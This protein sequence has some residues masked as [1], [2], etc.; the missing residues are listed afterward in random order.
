MPKTLPRSFRNARDV[1]QRTVRVRA[2]R[3]TQAHPVFAFEALQRFRIRKVVAVA[4]RDRA[5]PDLA[6]LVF[7][8][9]VRIGIGDFELHFLA[10]EFETCIAHQYAGQQACLAEDLEPV[11]D[12]KDAHTL[13]RRLRDGGHDAPARGDGAGAQIV[14]IGKAATEH[15]EVEIGQLS[16][17]MPDGH[18]LRAGDLVERAKHIPLAVRSWKDDD[19]GL[20]AHC[21]SISTA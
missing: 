9:E 3:V 7:A 20:H 15:H 17:G 18:G 8:R 14:A 2:F 12:A 21:S 6:L 16:F 10:D 11:T 4:M 1:V 5:A 13:V 19:A